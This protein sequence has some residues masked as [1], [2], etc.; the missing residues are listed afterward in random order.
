MHWFVYTTVTGKKNI[1]MSIWSETY[2]DMKKSDPWCLRDSYFV[3][4]GQ[5]LRMRV[6]VCVRM[7]AYVC[8]C[9][10]VCFCM[11]GSAVHANG[12]VKTVNVSCSNALS[13]TLPSADASL[14]KPDPQT[15]QALW[16]RR[17]HRPRSAGD[18]APGIFHH[19]SAQC[20]QEMFH[21]HKPVSVV[22]LLPKVWTLWRHMDCS[23]YT[24]VLLYLL[25]WEIQD[26]EASAVLTISPDNGR[27]PM[28]PLNPDDWTPKT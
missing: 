15:T 3:E 17:K 8:V 14:P 7:C 2:G 26:M 19:S 4:N 21:F 16:T 22:F 12:P 1:E 10:R 6:C 24:D 11:C 28:S 20:T 25:A 9:V 23:Q 27:I 18:E 5:A 13:T